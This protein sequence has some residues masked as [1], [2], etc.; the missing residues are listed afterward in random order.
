MSVKD[1]T[2]RVGRKMKPLLSGGEGAKACMS[3]KDRA[4][5]ERLA[6]RETETEQMNCKFQADLLNFTV[7]PWGCTNCSRKGG[8]G[9][10]VLV[11]VPVT[12]TETLYLFIC[13]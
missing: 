5:W 11:A 2:F 3:I 8:G 10:L 6:E 4:T 1:T 9:I 13:K 7:Q 12:F